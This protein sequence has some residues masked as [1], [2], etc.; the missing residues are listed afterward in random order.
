[1]NVKVYVEGGGNSQELRT[2]C[3]QGFSDFFRRAGLHGR[4]PRIVACGSRNDTYDSFCTA[5][6]IAGE[7][8]FAMLLVDSEAAVVQGA[9]MH[10]Q[11][12]DNWAQPSGTSDEN[13]Q[14]MVQVMEAWFLADR[15]RLAE[16]FGQ[17]FTANPL[18]DN[19][20]VE[21]IPKQ[22]V[23]DSLKLATRNSKTKGEYTK[24]KHSFQILAGLDPHKVSTSSNH[25]GRLLR[26]LDDKCG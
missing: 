9:W 13:A 5:V 23:F 15:K 7:D 14:L 20:N 4:M 1:M 21:E 25:A 24:G 22:V 3:R 19:K 16:Y 18:P 2:Q 10:L 11:S 6:N 8:D 17:G 26:T 12:R